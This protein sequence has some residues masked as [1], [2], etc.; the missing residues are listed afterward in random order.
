MFER[1]KS[2]ERAV[3]VHMALG[4]PVDPDE[5][6]EFIDLATSAGAEV[7][8]LVSGSRNQPDPRLFVGK[9]KAEEIRQIIESE[10][11]ELVIFD[12]NLSP[13]QE[14]NLEQYFK[15]RVLDRSGLIL[16]ISLRTS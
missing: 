1:P 12:H 6:Q 14:R 9:G 15:C 8:E 16:S 4:G 3:L 10:E 2:G 11:A 5:M 7:M 13:S